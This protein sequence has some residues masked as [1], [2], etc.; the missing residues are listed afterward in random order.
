MAIIQN[1]CKKTYE[2][3]MSP[4][5]KFIE[6]T[7]AVNT[8]ITQIRSRHTQHSLQS[9]SHVNVSCLIILIAFNLMIRTKLLYSS[10][11]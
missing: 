1:L 6:K 3:P 4:H 10:G 5:A 9:V 7:F 11:K 8:L 2:R